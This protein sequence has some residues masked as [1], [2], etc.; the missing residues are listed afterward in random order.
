MERREFRRSRNLYGRELTAAVTLLEGGINVLLF[1]GDREH[2]GAIS[3][4]DEEDGICVRDV[5]FPGH[6][7]TDIAHNWAESL[8]RQTGLPAVVEVGI[9]YD[10]IT[11]EVIEEVLRVTEKMLKEILREV[12]H[13]KEHWR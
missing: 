11:K 2:I 13:E 4:A 6:K 5:T 8:C 9:H 10:N 7:E 1:G 3:I 12:E